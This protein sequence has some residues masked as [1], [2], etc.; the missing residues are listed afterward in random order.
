[1]KKLLP[2]ILII[3]SFN[4]IAEVERVK[5]FSSVDKS[6]VCGESYISIDR[7][8]QVIFPEIDKEIG[9]N[10]QIIYKGITSHV[11]F[12]NIKKGF[13]YIVSTK[14][15]DDLPKDSSVLDRVEVRMKRYSK[16]F[17]DF[18]SGERGKGKFGRTYDFTLMHATNP[19]LLGN[20]PRPYPIGVLVSHGLNTEKID[21]LAVHRYFV[22]N[23]YMV[24]VAALLHTKDTFKNINKNEMISTGKDWVNMIEEGIKFGEF[25]ACKK[26]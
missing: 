11:T 22:S 24:E 9:I 17:P 23:G 6:R 7:N 12:Y 16:K 26:T 15:R 14:I 3:L 21:R 19:N 8:Y 5:L 10:E 25:T 20:K 1:M 4:T 18:F 13:L 2:V